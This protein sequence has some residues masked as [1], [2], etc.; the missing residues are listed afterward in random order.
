LMTPMVLF[1]K[2]PR[3]L[4]TPSALADLEQMAARVSQLPDITAIRGLTR[5]TGDPLEQTKVSYQA[6]EVGNKLD[7]A[8]NQIQNHNGD[9]DALTNGANKL[10]DALASVRSQVNDAVTKF[11]PMVTQLNNAENMLG[12]DKTIAAL[13]QASQLAGQMKAL[14][15]K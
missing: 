12:G 8:A 5:P 6:G 7:D 13:R 10:A 4:R 14:G 15:T 9:L 11:N 1:I 2:S 3:D